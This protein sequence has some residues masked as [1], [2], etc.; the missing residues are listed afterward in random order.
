MENKNCFRNDPGLCSQQVP[1]APVELIQEHSIEVLINE[2]PA[3][4]LTCTPEHLDELVVGR[5]LTEGLIASIDDIVSLYI[6]DQGLRARV[7]LKDGA[8]AQLHARE[9]ADVATCCTDNRVLLQRIAQTLPVLQPI[10][11]NE[12]QIQRLSACIR[13]SVPLYERTHAVHSCFLGCEDEILCGRE[14]IGR[15]NAVDKAVGWA[16][17]AGVD[18]ANCILF[19]TGRMPLDMVRKAIRA[20]VPVLASKT[21][22]T[23]E[24]VELAKKQGL[25]LLTL[26]PRGELVVWSG[27]QTN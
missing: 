4:R 24:A 17:L 5:L 7:F 16:S 27:T 10:A 18:L 13:E 8:G 15:H 22:P 12:M 14:D 26:P 21:Y 2:A 1:G 23:L 20:R 25:T 9:E 19:T 11:W 3:M 6:C